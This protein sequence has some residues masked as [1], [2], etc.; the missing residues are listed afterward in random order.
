MKRPIA[1]DSEQIKKRGR[2]HTMSMQIVLGIIFL[3]GLL[4][5]LLD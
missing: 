3:D 1:N 4:A 5:N 2:S